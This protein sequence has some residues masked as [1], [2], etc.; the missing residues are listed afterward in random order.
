MLKKI[1]KRVNNAL[2]IIYNY[3]PIELINDIIETPDYIEFRGACN[4]NILKFRVYNDG[5]VCE[6]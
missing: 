4:G 2:E 1:N 5:R 6:E 3:T